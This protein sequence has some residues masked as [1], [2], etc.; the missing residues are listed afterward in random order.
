MVKK[1]SNGFIKEKIKTDEKR[2]QR[3]DRNLRIFMCIFLIG[4]IFFYTSNYTFPKVYKTRELTIAGDSVEFDNL[5]LTLDTWDYSPK[6]KMFEIVFDVDNLNVTEKTK[7]NFTCRS[8]DNILPTVVHR[9]IEGNILVIRTKKVPSRFTD[10]SLM[11]RCNGS[12]SSIYSQDRV[13]HKVN[14]I[15]NRSDKDYR[16]YASRCRI[17]GYEYKVGKKDAAAKKTQQKI[18]LA[19]KKINALKRDMKY[20]T[21][22]EQE[23]TTGKIQDVEAEIINLGKDKENYESEKQ[24]YIERIKAQREL[25]KSL[26]EH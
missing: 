21:A 13:M 3:S 15:S 9:D 26:K 5:T 16:I 22:D 24:E 12:S 23:R 1:M 2:R 4:Y 20:Q 14:K 6:D 18:T 19:K 10:I 11:I 17:K 8:G 25:L 7:W